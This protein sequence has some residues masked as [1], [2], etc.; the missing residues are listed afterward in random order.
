M[1]L[2][3]LK[4][5]FKKIQLCVAFDRLNLDFTQKKQQNVF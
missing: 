3:L 4:I 1:T 5:N 2:I